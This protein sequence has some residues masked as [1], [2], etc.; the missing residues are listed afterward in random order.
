MKQLVHETRP[1]CHVDFNENG[2]G[3]NMQTKQR[4][5]I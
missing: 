1:G 2:I 3:K 4:I 5:A